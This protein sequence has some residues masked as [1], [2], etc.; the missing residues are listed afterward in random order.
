VADKVRARY[1]GLVDRI[2]FYRPFV[3]GV[4]EDRWRAVAARLQTEE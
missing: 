3:P 1:A 2:S 4:D